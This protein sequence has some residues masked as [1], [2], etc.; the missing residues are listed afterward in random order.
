MK[1][2][3]TLTELSKLLNKSK[4]TIWRWWA[5]DKILPPPLQ[6]KGRTLG[7]EQDVIEEWIIK[8]RR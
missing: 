7:W 8:S 6:Q 1:P 4:I 3:I 5:K 2:L